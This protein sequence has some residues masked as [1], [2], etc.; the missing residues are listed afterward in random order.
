[1]LV[2]QALR[3]A[4]FLGTT[5]LV[6]TLFALHVHRRA[7]RYLALSPRLSRAWLA[8]LIAGVLSALA[9]RLLPASSLA[10]ELGSFG[11]AITLGILISSILLWPFEL[12]QLARAVWRALRKSGE[13]ARAPEPAKP[14]SMPEPA[15][16]E[17][18]E[19][20]A[21][22]AVGSA[23]AVGFGASSYGALFGRHDYS[24]DTVS[25]ALQKLPRALDG[26]TIV[27]LSDIHVGLFVDE[28]ELRAGLELVKR[29]KPDLIVLTGDLVDHDP[30][31]APMLGRFARQLEGLARRG[32]F[33]IP[34][35][36]DYYAGV[37]PVMQALREAGVDVLLNRHVRVGDA[38]HGFALAGVDDVSAQGHGGAGP[39]LARAFAG[40]PP[41]LARVL[42]SH[43]PSFYPTAQSQAD[44]V[45]SGHTHGG[46][47]TL[48]I[49]PAELVLRHGYVRGHYSHG[50]SQIYVNRGFGTAGPPA[51]VGSPPEVTRIILTSPA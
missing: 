14:A 36:H 13:R 18:R 48:F 22:A 21:Q 34:G 43:N 19:F 1:V 32:V 39:D 9:A 2:S 11:A 41:E 27:Q 25:I 51:R 16:P 7:T 45:L 29:A 46:Q 31:Y 33:A 17:R 4:I 35:N 44:L 38:D 37:A 10:R 42:L 5:G 20:L 50:E 15:E 8:L 3:I 47:I 23:L 26:F 49:N 40:A 30:S 6:V 12:V 24:L 28:H